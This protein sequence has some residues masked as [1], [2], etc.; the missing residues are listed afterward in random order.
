[1]DEANADNDCS[2]SDAPKSICN[3]LEEEIAQLK[4]NN[5]S[6]S[7]QKLASVDVVSKRAIAL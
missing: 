1:M 3:S 5:K 6:S 4:A 2:I 7:K